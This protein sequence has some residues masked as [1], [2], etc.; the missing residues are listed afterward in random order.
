MVCVILT[1]AL[2]EDFLDKFTILCYNIVNRLRTE[3][4]THFYMFGPLAV[5]GI[6]CVGSALCAI[7]VQKRRITM[8]RTPLGV[9]E[10]LWE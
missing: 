9:V 3:T 6:L 8:L 1:Y 4:K 2:G 7:R 10:V 5:F